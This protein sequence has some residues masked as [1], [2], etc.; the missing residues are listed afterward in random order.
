MSALEAL[1][2][3]IA[4]AGLI[5]PGKPSL[6]RRVGFLLSTGSNE[7]NYKVG[8][9]LEGRKAGKGYGPKGKRRARTGTY[10]GVYATGVNKSEHVMDAIDALDEAIEKA[11]VV[12]LI[13][14]GSKRM[15]RV[16][17]RHAEK[18]YDGKSRA[19]TPK[20]QTRADRLKQYAG[21]RAS[22]LRSVRAGHPWSRD[23]VTWRVKKSSDAP[24]ALDQLDEAI[25]KARALSVKLS[26]AQRRNAVTSRLQTANSAKGLS[27]TRGGTGRS[28]LPS[29]SGRAF[30]PAD[31]MNGRAATRRWEGKNQGKYTLAANLRA[32]NESRAKRGLAPKKRTLL[33]RLK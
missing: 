28:K 10:T 12:G 26:P 31:G 30:V 29:G 15:A 17:N 27:R 18:K 33:G 13:R 21:L 3:A 7:R 4:K 8:R 6:L 32:I 19:G 22:G 11:K 20:G 2:E 1:A 25:E 5:K 24:T 16:A 9:Y 14:G 23:T